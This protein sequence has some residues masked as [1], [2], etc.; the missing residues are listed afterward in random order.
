MKISSHAFEKPTLLGLLLILYLS[1]LSGCKY[2]VSPLVSSPEYSES[3]KWLQFENAAHNFKLE[4]PE[5]W[6][7]NEYNENGYKGDKEVVSLIF[8]FTK[9]LPAIRITAK[10]MREPE[11]DLVV[12]WGEDRIKE[13]YA[14]Y[15]LEEIMYES[16]DNRQIA[17]RVYSTN[18]TTGVDEQNEDIYVLCG[19]EG[20]IF[21]FVGTRDDHENA[22]KFFSR[23]QESIQLT[24]EDE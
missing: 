18:M 5:G 10:E 11:L 20:L 3:A 2:I 23:M 21:S 19:E 1:F 24:C 7:A 16:L 9:M 4:Y 22:D 17:R 8:P 12:E 15:E 13:R 6:N 14:E